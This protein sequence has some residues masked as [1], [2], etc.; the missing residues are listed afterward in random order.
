ML[1]ARNLFRLQKKLNR[2]LNY[3][4][5]VLCCRMQARRIERFNACALSPRTSRTGIY[6]VLI[7]LHAPAP[8]REYDD[9][10][11]CWGPAFESQAD[12]DSKL[13]V[14]EWIL[15]LGAPERTKALR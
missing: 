9:Q 1:Y 3:A 12:A 6:L 2:F 7:D 11:P 8:R 15:T 13:R 5:S 4:Q 14:G 10:D